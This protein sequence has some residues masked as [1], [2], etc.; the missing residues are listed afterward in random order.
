MFFELGHFQLG[1][2]LHL[3]KRPEEAI[4]RLSTAI[5]L[6]PNYS[7]ALGQLGIVLVFTHRPKEGLELL[8]KAIQLSPKDPHLAFYMWAI[9]IDHFI[10][11]RYDEARIWAEK[12]LHENPNLPTGYRLLTSVHGMLNNLTE[13]HAAYKQ[14]D[15][16]APG[17]TIAACVEAVPFAYV[18]DATRFAEGLRRSGMPEE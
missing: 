8:H 4:Q 12:S 2:S 16:L 1:A 17:T 3:S 18:D 6:N 9:G 11:E 14:Y 13:A 5:K 7:R 15:R 10:E